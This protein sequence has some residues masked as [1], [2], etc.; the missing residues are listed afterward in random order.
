MHD[1]PPRRPD[2][3]ARLPASARVCLVSD[4]HLGDGSSADPF[5]RKDALFRRFLD[6]EASRAD[7]FVIVGDGFDVAQAWSMERIAHAHR[8]VLDDLAALARS[9]PLYYVAGN[10]E[11]SLSAIEDA[12]PARYCHALRIGERVLVE[13][14]HTYDPYN[15]PGDR[16]AFWASR[17]HTLLERLIRAPVRIPMRKHY[18]W[19]TRLGHWL[20][21]R[22][23]QLQRALAKAA[24]A[25]GRAEF[26]RRRDA[27]LDYWGQGEWGDAHGLLKA[28]RAVMH[29]PSI[30]VL[31]CGHSHQAG[32]LALEGGLYVNTGTWTFDD[33]TWA[34]WD[35]GRFSVRRFPDRGELRDQEYR[36]VLGPHGHRS[37]FDWWDTY[38][39][40]WLRYDVDRMRDGG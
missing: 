28:A 21:Y 38:Y 32:Q 27:F 6:Q 35:E 11:G 14:G 31:V 7:A 20:F 8:R 5:G 26:A 9:R 24:R 19:S 33:A 25:L 39:R 23:G 18:R 36:G 1:E 3:V 34:T 37:F 10:H 17:L 15:Q 29:D 2:A 12:L 16:A 40:G 30:D 13:H 22:Y 4:L